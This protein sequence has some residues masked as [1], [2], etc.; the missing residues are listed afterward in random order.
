MNEI[1]VPHITDIK[2]KGFHPIDKKKTIKKVNLLIDKFNTIDEILYQNGLMMI[3]EETNENK[4][5]K[6]LGVK[7]LDALYGISLT[8]TTHLQEKAI[9]ELK[10]T[11]EKQKEDFRKLIASLETSG[12]SL[13]DINKKIESSEYWKIFDSI[14]DGKKLKIIGEYYNKVSK[15]FERNFRATL[16]EYVVA[17]L[18][19]IKTYILE[20]EE[21]KLEEC[22]D[23]S[24]TLAK[25]LEFEATKTSFT[26][27]EKI[28]LETTASIL[29]EIAKI[30]KAKSGTLST[31]EIKILQRYFQGN[32]VFNSTKEIDPEE[33]KEKYFLPSMKNSNKETKKMIIILM[34]ILT[35]AGSKEETMKKT[36]VRNIKAYSQKYSKPK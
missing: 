33:I 13:K 35:D 9:N 10:T 22:I 21:E 1:L 4:I 2:Y 11:L 34:S 31:N 26:N 15:K 14:N 30:A 12:K 32:R 8:Y 5:I 25:M 19:V 23:Y 17:T 36:I 18:G 3:R 6:L 7:G 20:K 16:R 24:K 28:E 27:R 29:R